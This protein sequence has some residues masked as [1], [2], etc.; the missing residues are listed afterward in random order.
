MRLSEWRKSA[1]GQKVMT[2]K[3]AAAL[4][5]ALAGLGATAD[6]EAYVVWGDDPDLR[7]LVMAATPAGLAVINV[8]VNVPGE[9]PRAAGKLVRWARVQ[10][11]DLTTEAH[12]EHRYVTTQLE[13]AILQGADDAADQVTDWITTVYD[14][15][16]GRAGQAGRGEAGAGSGSTSG[17][18]SR[19]PA[20]AAG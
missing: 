18:K 2:G 12:H 9:G 1:Q 16:D 19:A 6:P 10:L 13:G 15:I 7:Y 17:S 11:G 20:R 5:P 14:H 8:R 4:E 3:V